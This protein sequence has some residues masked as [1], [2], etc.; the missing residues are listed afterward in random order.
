V[1]HYFDSR[2]VERTYG[3]SMRDGVWRLWRDDPDFAQRF[4]GAFEDGGSAI[5]GQWEA[6]HD[7]ATWEPDLAI[8]YHR[9]TSRTPA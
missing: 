3:T 7:G 9:A 6:S 5:G 2:G 1:M 4:V 8:K